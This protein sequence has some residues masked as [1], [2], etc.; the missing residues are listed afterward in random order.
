MSCRLW[1]QFIDKRDWGLEVLFQQTVLYLSS[2]SC[3]NIHGFCYSISYTKILIWV[4]LNVVTHSMS[5]LLWYID[6]ILNIAMN[7]DYSIMKTL[8]YTNRRLKELCSLSC[9]P[10]PMNLMENLPSNSVW[11]EPEPNFLKASR[12]MVF[13][14]SFVIH[15]D[16]KRISYKQ[17]NYTGE[18]IG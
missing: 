10:E 5:F 6:Y 2:P 14:N 18:W 12:N 4:T 11:T 1:M 8:C 9:D 7:K 16:T 15:H 17:P 3:T 13:K